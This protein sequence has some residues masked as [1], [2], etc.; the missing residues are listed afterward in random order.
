MHIKHII[1]TTAVILGCISTFSANSALKDR[2]NG[3]IY[4]STL[5]ITWVRDANLPKTSGYD[6]DGILSYQEA[7]DW[8]SNLS[9][10][11]YTDWRLP[12]AVNQFSSA[13][14]TGNGCSES[15]LGNLFYVSL[16]GISGDPIPA[17]PLFSNVVNDVYWS[18]TEP[19]FTYFS[20]L[21][22]DL[23]N[24]IQAGPGLYQPNFYAWAV[25][26]GDSLPVPELPT[27]YLM[28]IGAGCLYS[29]TRQRRSTQSI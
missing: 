17:S 8:V 2:G 14:C 18:I 15:E 6:S 16:G 21:W 25:R 4:D 10:A 3:L 20:Y 1:N 12:S 19:P 28:I 29:L 23:R 22:F 26:D 7:I 13:L 11:G 27:T 24:G 9:F 5:N